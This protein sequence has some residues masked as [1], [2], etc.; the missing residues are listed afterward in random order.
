[1]SS[2]VAGDGEHDKRCLMVAFHYPPCS[3]SSGYLRSEKFVRYLPEF[4]WQPEVLT[5]GVA[6]YGDGSEQHEPLPHVHRTY[7]FDARDKLSWRG[8]YLE[9]LALPDRWW[10]WL[11]GAIW[12]GRQLFRASRY[13]LIWSTYPT[14]TALLVGY[15]LKVLTGCPWVVDLRDPVIDEIHPRGRLKRWVFRKIEALAVRRSDTLVTTTIGARQ[16]YLTRYPRLGE[17]RVHCIGNGFDEADFVGLPS[18][19]AS[20]QAGAKKLSLIHSGTLYPVERNPVPFLNALARLKQEGCLASQPFEV[21]LRAT[22]HDDWL[23]GLIAERNLGEWVR[24]APAIGYRQALQ[25]M[26]EAD[27]LLVFQAANCPAQIPAKLYEYL[28]AGNP[29]FALAD[30]VGDTAALLREG[31]IAFLVD[32]TDEEAIAKVWVGFIERLASGNISAPDQ[33]WVAGFSR[34]RRAQSLAAVLDQLLESGHGFE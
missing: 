11:P 17:H 31:G 1:M 15:G 22:G 34:R 30:A 6:A 16:L 26:V 21:V 13:Q 33:D 32:L 24:L 12:R 19:S 9:L 10:S 14:P 7:A 4:G 20:P 28:R 29:V 27:G 2:A 18:L 25:E 5:A 8:K 3:T 23:R